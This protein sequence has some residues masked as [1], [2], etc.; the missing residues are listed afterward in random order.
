MGG[1]SIASVPMISKIVGA[2][3]LQLEAAASEGLR[4]TRATAFS[5]KRLGISLG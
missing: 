5:L 1:P 4:D 3:A 2:K